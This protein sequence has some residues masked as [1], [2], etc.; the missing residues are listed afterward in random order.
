MRHRR[1]SLLALVLLPGIAVAAACGS[2]NSATPDAGM[3]DSGVTPETST[4]DT[5][6]EA[7]V[8]DSGAQDSGAEAAGDGACPPPPSGPFVQA[9]HGPLPTM[10]YFGGPVLAAPQIVAFTFPTTANSAA[11]QA[12]SATIT[13][14]PW[15]AEVSRDYCINDGGTCIGP[16]PTGI[17]VPLTTAPDTSYVD[18]FGVDAGALGGTDLQQFIN[19][20]VLAAVTAKTIPAPGPSSLYVFYFPSTTTIT[21]DAPGQGGASC[22]SFG[23]YHNNMTYVDGTTQIAYAIL[24]DCAAGR[25][26]ELSSVTTA[27]SHEIIEATTDPQPSAR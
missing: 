7:A 21:I 20:Q 27:A 19:Q 1:V 16:G 4:Q 25:P 17:S 12:F 26:S 22:S 23:G 9:A 6:S 2:S 24:P 13:Q 15:F 11:L 18:T 5:G 10:A 3:A 8:V 14:T